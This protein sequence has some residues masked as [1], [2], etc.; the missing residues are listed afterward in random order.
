M[1]PEIGGSRVGLLV[2]PVPMIARV[3]AQHLLPVPIHHVTPGIVEVVDAHG[4][5]DEVLL[6]H[7]EVIELLLGETPTASS[8]V[9]SEHLWLERG[10][11]WLL[12]LS[13]STR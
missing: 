2:R 10:H 8:W 13:A 11:L 4:I 9:I 7:L 5:W 1:G 6:R 3:S 12:F